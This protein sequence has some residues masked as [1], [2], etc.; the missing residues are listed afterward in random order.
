M[1]KI[2]D[3]RIIGLQKKYGFEAMFIASLLMFIDFMVRI[4]FYKKGFIESI[5]LYFVMVL[6]WIYYYVRGLLGGIF[7][8][9]TKKEKA[10]VKIIGVFF[11]AILLLV[12][13]LGLSN[14]KILDFH[15]HIAFFAGLAVGLVIVA[16]GTS[17]IVAIAKK[18]QKS[19]EED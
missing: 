6:P 17:V 12:S 8:N 7:V 2:I 16:V 3:E 4:V 13:L 18:R 14:D 15:T 11:S 9:G 5:D 10:K 19:F 1:K